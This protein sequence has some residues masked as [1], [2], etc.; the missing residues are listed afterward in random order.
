MVTSAGLPGTS[1]VTSAVFLGTSLW[2]LPLGYRVRHFGYFRWFTGYVTLAT[3][4]GTGYITLATSV[5]LPGTSCWLL[6]LAYRPITLAT[7][8]G[9]PVDHTLA[10]LAGLLADHAG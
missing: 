5:G 7:L 4:A 2:L 10:T 6:W 8:P 3:L 9:L 1:L